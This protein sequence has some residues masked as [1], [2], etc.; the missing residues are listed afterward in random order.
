MKKSG[1]RPTAAHTN[2]LVWGFQQARDLGAALGIDQQSRENE[3]PREMRRP[4]YM[5]ARG[6]IQVDE[7][8]LA[9]LISAMEDAGLA[10]RRVTTEDA[11]A[12]LQDFGVVPPRDVLN[13]VQAGGPGTKSKL[14]RQI[15]GSTKRAGN[16]LDENAMEYGFQQLGAGL[17]SDEASDER[18]E[19][20]QY[21]R[22]AALMAAEEEEDEF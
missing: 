12:I 8:T 1:L 4:R 17:A 9:A 13:Y 14:F 19:R 3:R 7:E 15:F 11:V 6:V 21:G 2:A 10:G 22:M 5:G 16:D 20:E 18:W